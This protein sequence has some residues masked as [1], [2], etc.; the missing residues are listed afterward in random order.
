[1]ATTKVT[2]KL[3][4]ATGTQSTKYPFTFP[5]I[6]ST[7]II[8][9]VDDVYQD[10]TTKYT[11]PT[12]TEIQFTSGNT[13]TSGQVIKIFRDTN[14]DIAEATFASG[15]SI[16]AQDLNNNVEQVL[17]RLQEGVSSSSAP[18]TTPGIPS[19]T[20]DVNAIR[21][22]S[23]RQVI[24][25]NAA[26]TEAEWTSNV[27]L[28]GTLDVTG[29]ATFDTDVN[30]NTDLV[31]DDSDN[32]LKF[33]DNVKASFGDS[34]D[35]SMFWDGSKGIIESPSDIH[36]RTTSWATDLYLESDSSIILC[37]QNDSSEVFARFNDDS[38][39]SN[40]EL[41]YGGS[42]KFET[43]AAGC[44][45]IG[46]LDVSGSI[47]GI[48]GTPGTP[49]TGGY[50]P[51]ARTISMTGDVAWSVTVDG[52]ANVTAAGTIQTNA[53]EN[54]MLADNA[55]NTDEIVNNAV[56]VGKI[57]DAEL[58][59]L[60]GMQTGTASILASGTAL[61]AELAEINSICENRAAQTTITDDDLKIPTSG[62]VVDYVTSAIEPLGGLEVIP[63]EDSFPTTQPA[64]GVVISITNADGILVDSSNT[65]TTARTAGNGSDNVTINNF[66][67]T[68]KGGYTYQGLT[69]ANPFPLP[70]NTGLL[71]TST[72]SSNIY[73]YHKLLATEND[74][75]RLSDDIND[76]NERYR[77]GTSLPTT[78]KD[79][80][81][82][83]F[84]TDTGVMYVYDTTTTAWQPI[85]AVG[86]FYINTLSSSSGT[87]GGSASFNNTAYRF[88]LSNP[89]DTAQQLLVSIN[90]VVQK[91]NSGTS[92]PSEGFALD[93]TDI[94]F[95]SAPATSSDWFIITIGDS[96][97]IGTP[98]LDTVTTAHIVNGTILNEDI[99]VAADIAGSKLADDSIAEV[100]LDIHNAP[101]GTDKYLK[102]TSN[103]M[104]WATVAQYTTPLTTR[105]DILFRDATG[106]QRLPKGTS[107]Q[108]LI[109]GANEP[110]WDGLASIMPVNTYSISCADGDN[111]DEEKIRLTDANSNTDD[112]VLEAGTGLSIARSGD[113]ITFTNTIADT[114]L[115]TEEVQD[116]VG[117]MVSGNTETNIAV[118]YND[119]DGKLNFVSTDTNPPPLTTEEV[120]D[121][122]GA[123]F[124]GNTETRITATYE[125]SD[126]TIDLVV[127]DQS[128]DN[129]TTYSISC[130]DGDTAASEK[131]RLTAGGSGSGTDDVV[132]E[133]STG[134]T[135]AR[136][137]DTITYTNTVTDTSTFVGLTDTP[138]NYTSQA[139]KHIKVN[140]AANALEFTDAPAGTI[141]ALNNAAENRLVSIGATTTELD[142]EASLTF[143]D[144][145]STGLISNK[146][147]TGRG[148]ECPAEVSDDWTIA[149]ANNALFPGP[150]TVASGKT[151]TIP[152]NRT[153]TVV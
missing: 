24:Q 37:D 109:M 94:I 146:Q 87:G 30:F 147:I 82:L 118:T 17:F 13:P 84:K 141:T 25:T 83:F 54:S 20:V 69:N 126:G 110:E 71:V 39:G 7:D 67:D 57:A 38:A 96:V 142:G 33:K 2:S 32:K 68:L 131:I 21:P 14:V 26:G 10:P 129:D 91:P 135:I 122:V 136:S 73:N 8:V 27:D 138:A 50:W 114:N 134:L 29:A 151:V 79:S 61:V 119:T 104:E 77:V 28:P 81:D 88:T 95:S 111:T 113:K 74:V 97:S 23:A 70:P 41:F 40:V 80:G 5:Y 128:S 101:S 85:T 22:G 43:D 90:G 153:L 45:V 78:S 121:I 120:Q 15:S 19:G 137:G 99:N 127:D 3:H 93:N 1:M 123:M 150:M 125:D 48:I 139:G 148:F 55:V 60:A 102:Y 52:T 143:Q 115:T 107:G 75:K 133:A 140:A 4:T 49:G 58:K 9:E 103:G 16:R 66:P 89:P 108:I 46:D 72:G 112:V 132:L 59:T 6:R 116:I 117:G 56:T 100:K 44:N 34:D 11:F 76:F 51:Y 145:T 149:A 64:S 152:A 47:N 92:Q 62:A 105:G 144:T 12:A 42:K 31:W 65:S 130:V 35:F 124:S 98:S 106:D 53:V 36:I 86:E 63:N 18:G